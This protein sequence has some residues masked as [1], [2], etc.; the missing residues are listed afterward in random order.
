MLSGDKLD[1]INIR[2][3]QK[4]LSSA[5]ETYKKDTKNKE[6]SKA[7]SVIGA[8]LANAVRIY[9]GGDAS[10]MMD[11]FRK[12]EVKET[13][14][15][16]K[17]NIQKPITPGDKSKVGSVFKERGLSYLVVDRHMLM[18]SVAIGSDRFIVHN[19]QTFTFGP[20]IHRVYTGNV[21]NFSGL[22]EDDDKFNADISYW[23]MSAANNISRMFKNA[24]AFNKDLSSWKLKKTLYK[25]DFCTGAINWACKKPNNV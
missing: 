4:R 20:T 5:I 13:I 10:K 8:E 6:A 23:D 17:N 25:V 2:D 7:V 24:T 19:K 3:I 11:I 1:I 14:A 12:E 16:V 22:F 9:T 15:P 21:Y 18:S